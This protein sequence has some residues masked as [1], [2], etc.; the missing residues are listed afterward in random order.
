MFIFISAEAV[1]DI[2]IYGCDAY[3]RLPFCGDWSFWWPIERSCAFSWH[4]SLWSWLTMV[5]SKK[6]IFI[7]II[8]SCWWCYRWSSNILWI[9]FLSYI[10]AV[11]IV[12][13]LRLYHLWLN[14]FMLKFKYANF[15][16]SYHFEKR[17]MFF[18]YLPLAWWNS[19]KWADGGV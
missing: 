5:H 7:K 9:F 17:F 13:L 14:H 18:Y 3:I 15:I 10:W 4:A 6:L 11:A 8:V 19:L 16:D 1:F 2:A 12:P